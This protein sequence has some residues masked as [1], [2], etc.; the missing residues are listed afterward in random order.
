MKPIPPVDH[1]LQQ[2]LDQMEKEV[3]PPLGTEN[4]SVLYPL[5]VPLAQLRA[6][7]YASVYLHE[8]VRRSGTFVSYTWLTVWANKNVGS[9]TG[10]G[11][12]AARIVEAAVAEG[13]FASAHVVDGVFMSG[14]PKTKISDTSNAKPER[15]KRLSIPPSASE[16]LTVGPVAQFT[17]A[18]SS[19]SPI[20]MP[21]VMAIQSSSTEPVPP[22]VEEAPKPLPVVHDLLSVLPASGS[23]SLVPGA[24]ESAV[25]VVEITPPMTEK[26]RRRAAL[27]AILADS[28][29]NDPGTI[30]RRVFAENNPIRTG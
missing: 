7:G 20:T 5:L 17:T 8:F 16:S 19:S 4:D 18:P 3:P 12:Q 27:N 28:I 23:G 21:V 13:S 10:P 29:A 2:L 14:T 24:V 9:A 30:A 11:S 22:T 15:K 25:P 6:L 1:K 26:D